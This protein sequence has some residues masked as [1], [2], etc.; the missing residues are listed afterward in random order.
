MPRTAT[1]VGKNKTRKPTATSPKQLRRLTKDGLKSLLSGY[2]LPTTG[3]RPQLLQRLTKHMKSPKRLR[4]TKQTRIQ[5]ADQAGS[6]TPRA[7]HQL[8]TYDGSEPSGSERSP[9][10]AKNLTDSESSDSGS[11]RQSTTDHHTGSKG[12]QS[13]RS[14][15]P[16]GEHLPSGRRRPHKRVSPSSDNP[17]TP[18]LPSGRHTSRHERYHHSTPRKRRRYHRS[19][20]SSSTSSYTS[21][22]STSTSSSSWTGSSDSDRSTRYRRR[23]ARHRKYHRHTRRHSVKDDWLNPSARGSIPCA[24]PLSRR[25]QH[26][27]QR[28]KYVSFSKLLLPH[29]TLPIINPTKSKSHRNKT[30]R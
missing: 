7:R 1:Q 15:S 8:P 26:A 23:R 3:T 4:K 22:S 25:L 5:V 21:S 18:H 17:H 29:D 11:S 16:S 27:I 14:A 30:K 28:G 6:G 10:S 12:K 9:T 19:P 13:R 2:K 24:P 20:D